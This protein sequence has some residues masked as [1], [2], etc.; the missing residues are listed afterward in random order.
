LYLHAMPYAIA[1]RSQTNVPVILWMGAQHAD[2]DLQ[3]VLRAKDNNFSH[4]NVFHT[5]LGLFE[6]ES[7]VYQPRLD[8]INL[9]I[10]KH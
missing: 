3:R 10:K 4:H 5:L 8:L 6:I 2:Y 1:P 9:G 7:E